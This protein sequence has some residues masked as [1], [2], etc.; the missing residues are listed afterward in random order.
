M[1]SKS[2][3]WLLPLEGD[4][5][6]RV[7]LNTEFNERDG[8]FSPDTHWVAYES[9]ENGNS[10]IYVRPFPDPSKAKWLVSRG[11]GTNPRWRGDSKELYYL[12]PD[13]S[14]MAVEVTSGASFQPGVP[15]ALFKVEGAEGF[16]V[17]ADAKKFMV[18]VPTADSSPVPVTVMVNW[19]SALKK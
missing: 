18:G 2:D 12:A 11:G 15:K 14:L 3:L 9:D 17:S 10:E 19:P 8:Q 13:Q 16:G 4:R 6:R 7:F 1:K 5:N